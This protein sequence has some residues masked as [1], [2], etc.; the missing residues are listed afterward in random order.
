M[1]PRSRTSTSSTRARWIGS[2]LRKDELVQLTEDHSLINE[3]LKRG[4]LTR[5][6]IE[7][8]Q[9]KNA[10]TRAVGVYASVEVDTFDFD[11][12]PGD[13]FLLSSDGLYAYVDEATLQDR[14][15]HR[16]RQSMRR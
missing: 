12:L 5:D 11:I 3:L 8:V 4:R 16:T 2:S 15:R 14:P 6:Q 7:K 1:P 13:R 10:V 9:Y